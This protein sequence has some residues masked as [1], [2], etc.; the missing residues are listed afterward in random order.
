MLQCI[1]ITECSVSNKCFLIELFSIFC[2]DCS[3]H[4]GK[5]S[6]L[7][8]DK[9]RSVQPMYLLPQIQM[10][11]YI[12]LDV[13]RTGALSFAEGRSMLRVLFKMIYLAARNV[14]FTSFL[15]HW[16]LILWIKSSLYCNWIKTGF[17]G[18]INTLSGLPFSLQSLLINEMDSHYCINSPLYCLFHKLILPRNKSSWLWTIM[19]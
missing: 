14:F 1:W 7:R 4:L 13:S 6:F 9:H 11:S 3:S 12:Q 10:I 5:C 15:R 19:S 18:T 8:V 17:L 2:F 16:V